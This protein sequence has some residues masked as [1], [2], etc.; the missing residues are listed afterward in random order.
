MEP[1]VIEFDGPPSSPFV[2]EVEMNSRRPSTQWQPAEAGSVVDE[3][4]VQHTC[5]T[6]A[7]SI[8]LFDNIGENK[9]NVP[10]DEPTESLKMVF[11]PPRQPATPERVPTKLSTPEPQPVL[12]S[13]RHDS[14]DLDL[15]PP[16]PS[17]RKATPKKTPLKPSRSATNTPLPPSRNNSYE[18]STPRAEQTKK[19]FQAG[20]DMRNSSPVPQDAA[21][22]DDTCFSTFSEMPDMTIFAKLGQS[23]T[24]RGGIQRIPGGKADATPRT[25]RKRSSPSRSPSPTPR[26]QRIP[27]APNSDGTTS[28]LID[29]TQ[30]MDG[31][32][33]YRSTSPGKSATESNLLQYINN[34]R[35]PNKARQAY[36][37]PSK[38][39][40]ILHLLDFE[41]PPAPTPRSVPTITV[42][43]L[44]SLK[45]SYL[46]QISSLKATLSGREAEVESL[47]KAVGDAERRVGEAQRPREHVEQE[48]AEWEKRGKE[49][50]QVLNSVKEEVMKSEAEK[51]EMARKAEDSE[52][53]VDDAEA[54]AVRAEE[55]FAD[56]LAAR[57][58]NT[59]EGDASAVEDQVQRLVAA[60]IDA[61]IEAVSRELHSVYKG[62][63]ERKVGTLKKSYEAR[64][65]RKC[66]ELQA[67]VAEM[68]T[69]NEELS[70]A[71]DATFSGPVAVDAELKAQ[72]EE[73]KAARARLEKEMQTSQRQQEQLMRELQQERIE[74]GD[75]VAAVDEMLMLQSENGGGSGGSRPAN[76]TA[77]AALSVVEDFR[78]S[79]SRPLGLRPLGAG[80]AGQSRIGGLGGA[81][82][83][84]S[85]SGGGGGLG[86]KSR[87]LSNIERMGR[88]GGAGAPE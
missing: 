3:E 40:N 39:N 24:K 7:K 88:T 66:A 18:R 35:S 81:A 17:T 56:A 45:S 64:S 87:L 77:A 14:I 5:N 6:P 37:T 2:T 31:V 83:G 51:D 84:R 82:M 13:E 70:A 20:L 67:R 59:G 55:R 52:R 30:Q 76:A 21:S 53:R 10:H 28:F 16:P 85:M 34:Q 74:K 4:D 50:E 80:G 46:S 73:Q 69:R 19:T 41:L 22:V 62:K 49:V 48:K 38:P 1:S 78:K 58:S 8:I 36:T 47:K 57:A 71:K 61:K 32:N 27:A 29:F 79:I 11:P 60:Q 86:G 33:S 23:A 42:R 12:Q 15:M 63:H 43:E 72:V 65:E 9:E 75:L 26:R 25:T 44:E 54:R 68:E